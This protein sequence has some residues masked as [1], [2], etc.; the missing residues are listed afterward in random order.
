[1][2][3]G[4]LFVSLIAWVA[5]GFCQE[6]TM[7]SA[8]TG[9]ACYEIKYAD[10][11]L[12]V[13]T[14]STF[15]VYD[16][17]NP[18][19]IPYDLL[20]EYRFKSN[21][22]DIQ[23]HN[24]FLYIAANHDGLSKWDIS[25]PTHPVMI[26]EYIP[27]A[28]DEAAADLSFRNDSIFV[29]MESKIVVFRDEGTSFERL[30]DFGS[31]NDIFGNGF[32]RGGEIRNNIYVYTMGF[33]TND[34]GEGVYVVDA[35]T[36][37]ELA[38]HPRSF[39]DGE[40]VL[41]GTADNFC[42]VLGGGQYTTSVFGG[43]NSQ[44]GLFFTL[45]ITNPS[46]PIEVFA[47]TLVGFDFLGPLVLAFSP[48]APLNA[49]IQN[50]TIYVATVAASDPAFTLLDSAAGDVYVYDA[51]IP[52]ETHRITTF[53]QGLWHFDLDVHDDVVFVA[54][55]WYGIVSIN[56]ADLFNTYEI[57]R[58]LTGGW[59]LASD[60]RNEKLVVCNEGYGFKIFDAS[61][62]RN[63]HLI[64]VNNDPGFCL[65]I[66]FSADGS[67]LYGFYLTGDPMRVFDADNLI[68]IGR[69]D[70]GALSLNEYY[71]EV[72]VYKNK[73][74]TMRENGNGLRIY[75]VANGNTPFEETTIN[76]NN[77]FDFV[78]TS[79]GTL[80]A[81]TNNSMI[82]YDLENGFAQIQTI[83]ASGQAFQAIAESRDTVFVYQN[84]AGI[85]VYE[86]NGTNRML[87]YQGV[88]DLPS[89]NPLSMAADDYGL[90]CAYRHDQLYAYDKSDLTLLST[91][92]T[93][94]GFVY[95]ATFGVEELNTRENVIILSEYF[96]QT[97]LLTM[98]PDIINAI[99]LPVLNMVQPLDI[100]PSLCSK[101]CALTFKVDVAMT[102]EKNQLNVYDLNGQ[103]MY[104]SVI[105][106]A[107]NSVS[108]VRWPTGI[109]LV[110]VEYD[111]QVKQSGRFVKQ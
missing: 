49:A 111:G 65:N 59:N 61:D 97:T 104:S 22:D 42:H 108:A 28:L 62:L 84:N 32:I 85:Q 37:A 109:Y 75:D 55:E 70:A 38:F 74:I 44:D 77:I 82:T 48:A 1:M 68:E 15:R 6:L 33:R 53:E 54:S 105:D 87:T 36:L 21:I 99:Q 47:D 8:T 100:H 102:G 83:P 103:L 50:D 64:G 106:H 91:Y 10:G 16:A 45:D 26:A 7:L 52:Q 24:G 12:F 79:N 98:E 69:V 30:A 76:V 110:T 57:G 71:E 78:I 23:I 94:L 67:Q 4:M 13:G 89:G 19:G 34:Q 35:N 2:K 96:A 80:I 41:F 90:Y 81:S 14:G 92:R 63:P 60:Y 107:T 86:Y 88:F 101:D 5:T 56:K 46:N 40:D 66:K 39:G 43:P 25:T 17:R 93:G 51:T 11:L 31:F 29:A 9:A 58:T 72:Q 95:P 18:N 27:S 73:A 20:F 3:K